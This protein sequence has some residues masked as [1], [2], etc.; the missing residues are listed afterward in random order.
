MPLVRYICRTSV[1]GILRRW[2]IRTRGGRHLQH[3]RALAFAEARH[4]ND[5]AVGKFQR[6]V[7]HARLVRVDLPETR[8]T[9]ADLAG[10]QNAERRFAFDIPLNASSV[11]GSRQT[12]TFVL[13]LDE[14]PPVGVLTNLVVISL[15]PTLAGR[16]ATWCRL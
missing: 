16:L 1:G 11:P 10:G 3:A 8:Q 7:V 13:S 4:E 15:S 14:K 6:V 5:L 9:L 2:T 12:A